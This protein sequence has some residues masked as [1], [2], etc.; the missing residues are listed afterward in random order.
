MT[1]GGATVDPLLD[2]QLR[3]I[4]ARRNWKNVVNKQ[5]FDPTLQQHRE[6]TENDDLGTEVT[7]ALQ[8]VIQQQIEA[9]NTLKDHSTIHFTMQ[10]NTF[11]HAFQST[12]FTVREFREG[13]ERLETYLH[14]LAA[15]LN[16]NEEFTP[17]DTFTMETTFIH[18]P[19][20]GSGR[21]HY[22]PSSAAVR[23]I[24]KRSRVT[25]KNDDEL[26][27]RQ[28]HCDHENLRGCWWRLSGPRLPQ[29]Q[30]GSSRSKTQ[31]L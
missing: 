28:S 21:K 25:I 12:T 9:D 31:R 2:F 24:T 19:G 30:T 7:Q 27:L 26:S 4:G 13:S 18:T 6:A 5:R 10:S 1:G 3:P 14:A 8:R 16:S 22:K 15:K 20:P 23:G 11:T 29:P 17:D